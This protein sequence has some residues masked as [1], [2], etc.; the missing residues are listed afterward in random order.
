MKVAIITDTHF[1]VKNASDVF[2]DHMV[3]FLNEEFFPYLIDNGITEILHLGDLFDNRQ[4]I[5]VKTLRLVQDQFLGKLREYN[6]KMHIIPGNHDVAYKNTNKLS[7]TCEVLTHFK[8]VATLHMD[9]GVVDYDGLKI[10]LIPWI[11]SE[12]YD[13]VMDFV[14]KVDAPIL[15][16]HLELI[17][18]EMMK[19]NIV[20]HH[21]MDPKLFSRFEYVMSGHYHTR[22]QKDNIRYL[23]TPYE[24]TWA[25]CNDPKGFHILDTTTRELEDIPNPNRMFHKLVY[26]D[27]DFHKKSNAIK[28]TPRVDNIADSYVKVVVV[29]KHDPYLFDQF[30]DKALAQ[31]PFDL[32]IIETFDEYLAENVDD[33]MIEHQDTLT[34][35]NSYMDVLETPLEVDK[36]KSMLQ[37]LYV[38]AQ[39]TMI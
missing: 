33:D 21:G 32:K 25:D 10:A 17:G 16:G 6:M 2:S 19:G 9:P 26:N 11:N 31:S 5:N 1:G 15:G 12:N 22:S 39:N 28:F 3:N 14:S 20:Q 35:L 36:L 23:G 34:I 38:E 30:I 18:F 29:K 27:S 7:A 8:D 24:L 37:A 13:E 4:S